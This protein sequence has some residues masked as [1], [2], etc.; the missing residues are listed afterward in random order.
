MAI[1]MRNVT[2]PARCAMLV[3]RAARWSNFNLHH[4]YLESESFAKVLQLQR[5]YAGA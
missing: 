1:L 2:N 5:L 3:Q 4:I